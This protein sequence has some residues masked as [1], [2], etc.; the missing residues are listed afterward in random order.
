MMKAACDAGPCPGRWTL[1]HCFRFMITFP[2]RCSHVFNLTEDQ[3]GGMIQCP[4]CGLLND[5]PRLSDLAGL[6]ADGTIK[7]DE[8]AQIPEADRLAQVS[9]AFAR[10]PPGAEEI[11]LRPTI[12]EVERVGDTPPAGGRPPR[13]KPK[14]DPVTGELIRPLDVRIDHAADAAPVPLARRALTYSAGESIRPLNAVRLLLELFQPVNFFVIFIIMVACVLMEVLAM[15]SGYLMLLVG[16][17]FWVLDLPLAALLLA[18]YGNVIDDTG[19]EGR[20]ELPRPMRELSW[21]D[22]LWGPFVKLVTGLAVCY[23]PLILVTQLLDQ[24]PW[25][26]PLGLVLFL[27]GSYALPAVW[28]TLIASGSILNLRPDRLWGVIRLCGM[29]YFVPLLAA[30]PAALGHAW[31]PLALALASSGFALRHPWVI[32]LNHYAVVFSMLLVGIYFA[33]YFAWYLGLLY[34]HHHKA[35]PWVFQRHVPRQ[36]PRLIR[37]APHEPDEG[38]R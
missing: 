13:L 4:R 18:H 15:F 8:L 29:G 17:P 38:K 35:F 31:G 2:C 28:L 12:E 30:I 3:A 34:R 23:W 20:D 1:L 24:S 10:R 19:R 25:A 37:R 7:L 6:A 14:Y 22:D 5:V 36:D 16:L 26:L 27:A 32:Y 21:H 33:H 11:D 9:R